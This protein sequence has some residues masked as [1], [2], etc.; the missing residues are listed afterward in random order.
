[1]P[2]SSGVA[3][4]R[5][6]VARMSQDC[7]PDDPKL[8]D[9]KRDLAAEKINDYIDKTLKNAPPLTDAQRSQL[10]ELLKPV[11]RNGGAA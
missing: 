3:N 1:M 8:V 4:R 10:A 2:I 7:E 6:R 11:R 9:A 5:A